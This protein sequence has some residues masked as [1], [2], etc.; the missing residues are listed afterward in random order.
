MHGFA[1]VAHRFFHEQ[2]VASQPIDQNRP[3]GPFAER[4][5][6]VECYGREDTCGANHVREGI[7]TVLPLSN[8]NSGLRARLFGLKHQHSRVYSELPNSQRLA[9]SSSSSNGIRSKMM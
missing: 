4:R 2:A 1:K 7:G 6:G 3:V 8:G 9:G 5:A